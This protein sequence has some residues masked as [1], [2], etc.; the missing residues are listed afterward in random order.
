MRKPKKKLFRRGNAQQ[1][2][3]HLVSSSVRYKHNESTTFHV[4]SHLFF[5][6]FLA[7]CFGFILFTMMPALNIL[8]NNYFQMPSLTIPH[9]TTPNINLPQMPSIVIDF[10]PVSSSISSIYNSTISYL[11][12]L[13]PSPLIIFIFSTAG[14][15]W[16]YTIG[17]ILDSYHLTITQVQKIDLTPTISFMVGNINIFFQ[18]VFMASKISISFL[19]PVPVLYTAFIMQLYIASFVYSVAFFLL[20][21]LID[22]IKVTTQA[23][24]QVLLAFFEILSFVF[25][26]ILSAI[27][28]LLVTIGNF[29]NSIGRSIHST[30][31]NTTNFFKP[32]VSYIYNIEKQSLADLG[33]GMNNLTGATKVLMEK[34]K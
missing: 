6:F 17:L 7:A 3:K 4:T 20:G 11:K 23:V 10:Q 26:G 28:A 31:E 13:N 29:F 21:L 15:I 34:G 32:Y 1:Y 27:E 19:N 33:D 8:R 30:S 9:I 5:Y 22:G 24:S 18:F 2:N 16:K 25:F 14:N 12:I